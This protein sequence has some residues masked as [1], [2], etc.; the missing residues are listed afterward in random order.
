MLQKQSRH[1]KGR[2]Y[3]LNST[4][5]IKLVKWNFGLKALETGCITNNQID[6]V[7]KYLKKVIFDKKNTLILSRIRAHYSRSR[8]KK[9]IRMGGS[10]GAF[11]NFI[12]R[13]RVGTILFEIKGYPFFYFL[14]YLKNV[15]RLLSIK[16]AIVY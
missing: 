13:V 3:G 6:T 1:R 9:G 16:V 12:Y 10:R 7:R 11:F 15:S 8:K 14:K 4:T 2:L 5:K